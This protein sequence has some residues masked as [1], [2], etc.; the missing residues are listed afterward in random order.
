MTAITEFLRQQKKAG[1]PRR[2]AQRQKGWLD[3]VEG[4]LGHIRSW[5]AEAQRE[6]LIKIRP[7]K[8]KI[9]EE[10]LGTYTAPY[11]VLTA[12]GKIVKVKPIGNT[13]IGADGRVDMESANGTF[14]FLYLADQDTWVYGVGRQPS[15][16]PDLTED[17]FTDILK[18]ALS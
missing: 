1:S 12:A 11:L 7:D 14:M 10:N 6:K 9:T 16:F 2:R 17:L 8:I 4:L 3:A 18:R 5:L 13:I 15:E